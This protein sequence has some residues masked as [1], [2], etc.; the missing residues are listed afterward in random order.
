MTRARLIPFKCLP[1]DENMATDEYLLSYFERTKIPVLRLYGWETPAITLGRNQSSDP[2][3]LKLCRNDSVNIIRRMTG[4]GAI[5]HFDEVTYSFVCPDRDAGGNTLSVPESYELIN[6]AIIELYR[7]LG[8]EAFYAKE[9]SPEK[10]EFSHFCFSGREEYDIIIKNRKVGGNAQRRIKKAVF[11]HGSIPL[12]FDSGIIIKYFRS[13]IDSRNFTTLNEILGREVH[14]QEVA[15]AIIS[16]FEKMLKM[17]FFIEDIQKPEQY[18]I[19]ALMRNKYQSP[20]WNLE[21]R[22]D[23]IEIKAGMAQ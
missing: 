6:S 10:K 20:S 1:G 7:S 11:Q 16:S 18:A 3:N 22:T 4:G 9:T 2:I 17:K 23:G 12:S 14:K 5:F 8:L 15:D 13:R 21:G 19:D